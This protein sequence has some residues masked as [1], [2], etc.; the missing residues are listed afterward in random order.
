MALAGTALLPGL[1][2]AQAFPSKPVRLIVPFP[3]GGPSGVL[4]RVIADAM[5]EPLGQPVVVD[6]R[7]GAGGLIGAEAAAR[8]LPDGYTMFFATVGTHGINSALYPKLPYDPVGDFDPVV[9][10]ASAA[11]VIICNPSTPYRTLA[12]LISAAKAQPKTI[13]IA[14]GGNGTAVHMV[15]ELLRSMAGIEV[16]PVPYR[17]GGPAMTDLLGGHVGV[18]VDGLPAAIAQIR[19]G[20]V[21]ALAVSSSGRSPFMPE[22]PTVSETVPGFEAVSWW[23]LLVPRGTPVN[24]INALNAAANKALA[25]QALVEKLKGLGAVGLG[26]TPAHFGTVIAEEIAKWPPVVRATGAKLS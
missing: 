6:N 3:P 9:L 16:T 5:A 2:R 11:N 17:G 13:S 23:G 22:I 7:G 8:S 20:R 24:A 1:A 12:D 25:S 10:A 21:R 14:H 18:M 26:G 19:D 15:I 4:A